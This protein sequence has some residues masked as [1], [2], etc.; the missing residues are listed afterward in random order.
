MDFLSKAKRA[1]EQ[2]AGGDAGKGHKQTD[3]HKQTETKEKGKATAGGSVLAKAADAAEKYHAKE[4]IAEFVQKRGTAHGHAPQQSGDAAKRNTSA[5]E[6]A[7][8]KAEGFL[9][10]QSGQA[11]G[12]GQ[13]ADGKKDAH[14]GDKTLV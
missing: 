10:K 12:H 6:K 9:A 13:H 1:A 4:K 14:K 3:H 2:Y 5:I 11:K 8:E 7:V